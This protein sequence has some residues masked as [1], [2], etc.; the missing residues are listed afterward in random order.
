MLQDRER[1]LEE[2]YY[3]DE[4]KKFKAIVRAVE[5][6]GAYISQLLG[7]SPEATQTLVERYATCHLMSGSMDDVLALAQG[8]LNA[9]EL[10]SCPLILKKEFEE[11]FRQALHTIK[12]GEE[13]F[14]VP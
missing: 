10:D 8:D 2:L 7:L 9:S 14:G 1:A 4:E 5:H 12:E 6:F 3:L 13:K 11:H